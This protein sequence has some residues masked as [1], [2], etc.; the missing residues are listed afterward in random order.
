VL[1]K[2][3]EECSL[4]LY[5]E[6]TKIV[7]C[8]DGKRNGRYTSKKFTFLG[9]TF[10]PRSAQNRRTRKNFTRFLPAVSVAAAKKFRANIKD[11]GIVKMHHLSLEKLAEQVNPIIRDWY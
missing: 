11:I 9:Y 3:L 10:K 8:R 1:A 4:K 6:K 5:L 7:Y 2:R